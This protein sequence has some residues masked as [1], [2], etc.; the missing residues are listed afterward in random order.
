MQIKL[1]SHIFVFHFICKEEELKEHREK[2]ED[3]DEVSDV[4]RAI[5]AAKGG[6]GRQVEKK[7]E[8]VHITG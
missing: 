7:K 3:G 5:T 4:R 1:K 8:K 6:E 2:K